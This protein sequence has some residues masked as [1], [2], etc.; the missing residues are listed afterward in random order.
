M[1]NPSIDHAFYAQLQQDIDRVDS[2]ADTYRLVY[3]S[4]RICLILVASAVTLVSGWTGAEADALALKWLLVL[5]VV[6]TVIT[7]MDTLF[8]VETKKNTY[9]LMLVELREVR[10]EF[11][12]YF[13]HQRSD[14][15]TV[16][17]DKLFPKYQ[18]IKAY[19][20]ALVEQEREKEI[21]AKP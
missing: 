5:G 10:S 6:T 3:Y 18:A 12:F 15:E 17:R 14:L 4:F 16:L 9:R 8:G 11:V 21:P 20:K 7:A 19:T 2:K 1:K 13:D